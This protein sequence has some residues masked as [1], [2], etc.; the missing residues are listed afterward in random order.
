VAGASFIKCFSRLQKMLALGSVRFAHRH[1]FK[2][3]A[4]GADVMITI[5]CDFCQFS[6]MKT[7]VFLE[8]QCNDLNFAK[9]NIIFNKKRVLSPN[10][11]AKL[12][13]KS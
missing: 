6:A 2:K 3:L 1:S 7:G 8:N 4:S 13:K 10:F 11:L 5:F 12:F 9:T